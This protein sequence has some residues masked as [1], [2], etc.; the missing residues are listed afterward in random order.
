MLFQNEG[1]RVRE[2]ERKDAHLLAKW[3]SDPR[4]LEFYEGRDNPFDLVKVN[5]VFFD[6]EVDE[7]KCIV[8]FGGIE[9]GYVQF[10]PVDDETKQQYGYGDG[11]IYGTDQFIGE[12]EYWNKGI[13]SSLVEGMIKFLKS[14]KHADY[15]I[16][17]PQTRNK[18]A[19]KCYEK[20]GFKK[21]KLLPERELHEGVYQDCW[22]MEYR[23]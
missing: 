9:V 19:I 18:R 22:L 8:E 21:V 13:G 12:P 23:T 16:M 6:D 3:L 20:C 11:S 15:I 5:E 1:L 2:M 17:D 4:V 7:V 10:Y 14:D